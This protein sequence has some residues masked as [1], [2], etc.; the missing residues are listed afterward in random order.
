MILK[1]IVEHKK[2]ELS[3]Q[4]KQSISLLEDEI[5]KARPPRSFAS[6]IKRGK[7]G[8]VKV[9]AEV[10]KASPSKGV[11]QKNFNPEKIALE[12]AAGGAS[13]ISV[14]TDE[15]FFQGSLAN[16][17]RVVSA[18]DVPVLRKEFII[19]PYQIYEARLNG[20]DAILLIA[21]VLAEEELSEFLALSNLLGMDAL[22]E[23]HDYSELE[24][25]LKV[26]ADII[27]INNRNLNDFSVSIDTTFEL[28]PHI[29]TEKI[30]VSESGI[31]HENINLLNGKV[32]AVLVG[33][34]IV[35]AENREVAL[36]NLINASLKVG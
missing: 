5:K 28:L 7:K 1:K 21:G 26:G 33:E 14:L 31:T 24:I 16:M 19:D 11:I 36:T 9:I 8:E 22:V 2:I 25:A 20:A 35:K 34:S 3:Q 17:K 27:G 10:K 29:P 13:A 18:C 15:K 32:D 23:V 4:E 12:Y 6:A 30:V